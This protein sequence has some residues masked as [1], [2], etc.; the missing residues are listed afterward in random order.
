MELGE[1][2]AGLAT[3]SCCLPFEDHLLMESLPP[4]EE[5]VA[6]SWRKA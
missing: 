6:T 5:G 3:A 1:G 2:V 4:R